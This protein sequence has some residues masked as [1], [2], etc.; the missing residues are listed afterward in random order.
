[1][2]FDVKKLLDEFYPPHEFGKWIAV[3]CNLPPNGEPVLANWDMYGG[4]VGVAWIRRGKWR[5]I[6]GVAS[7][8]T[9]WMPLPSPPDEAT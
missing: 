6:E 7:T 1:M 3:D 4:L 5:D 8:P 9:H 2:P